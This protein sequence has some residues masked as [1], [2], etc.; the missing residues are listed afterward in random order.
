M[1]NTPLRGLIKKSPLATNTELADR[2]YSRSKVDK[3]LIE[4]GEHTEGNLRG[5]KD[6]TPN[7]GSNTGSGVRPTNTTEY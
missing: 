6:T 7:V 5:K 1:R 2:V 4:K 3:S